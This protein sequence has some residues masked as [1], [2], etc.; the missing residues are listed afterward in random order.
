MTRILNF[1]II[2][3]LFAL[4][5]DAS[6]ELEQRSFEGGNLVCQF[7]GCAAK[8]AQAFVEDRDGAKYKA[9]ATQCYKNPVCTWNGKSVLETVQSYSSSIPYGDDALPAPESPEPVERNVASPSVAE[10]GMAGLPEPVQ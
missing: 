3:L 7:N 6:A 10:G 2:G 5:L 8:C 9:C 4:S 1:V